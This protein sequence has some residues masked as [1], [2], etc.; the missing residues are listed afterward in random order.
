MN[1]RITYYFFIILIRLCKFIFTKVNC[2]VNRMG[3]IMHFL[4]SWMP[5]RNKSLC[6]RFKFQCLIYNKI[7]QYCVIVGMTYD[8]NS[9]F[10]NKLKYHLSNILEILFDVIIFYINLIKIR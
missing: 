4:K 6:S 7:S 5:Y 2:D 9:I 10:H 8:E 3:K 1:V